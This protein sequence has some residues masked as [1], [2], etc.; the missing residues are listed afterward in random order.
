MPPGYDIV[1]SAYTCPKFDHALY[2]ERVLLELL[3]ESGILTV[4]DSK[5]VRER[6]A[7]I[8]ARYFENNQRRTSP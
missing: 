7:T 2:V 1:L 5:A 4:S 3:I 6:L 8:P